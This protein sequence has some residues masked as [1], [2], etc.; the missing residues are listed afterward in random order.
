MLAHIVKNQLENIF[1]FNIIRNMSYFR[2]SV[3]NLFCFD[4]SYK[5]LI[6]V[7]KKKSQSVFNQVKIST[8]LNVRRLT[9]SKGKTTT[10]KKKKKT[11]NLSKF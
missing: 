1:G 3:M 9:S 6:T 2:K 11:G 7:K 8:S 4:A 10:K 5:C